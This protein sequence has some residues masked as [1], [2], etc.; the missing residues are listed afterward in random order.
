MEHTPS[1]AHA[2]SASPFQVDNTLE[3]KLWRSSKLADY[4]IDI[5]GLIVPIVDPYQLSELEKQQLL[6]HCRKT[7]FAIYRFLSPKI[8]VDK[9]V[10]QALTAQLGLHH[11]DHNLGADEDGVTA[12]QVSP[13]LG[14]QEYIPYTN[15]P[16]NWHTDGYYNSPEC[17]VHAFLIHCVHPALK[18]GE[19]QLYDHELAYIKLRDINPEYV[20][21]LMLPDVMT[22][23]ANQEGT[24]LIRAAQTGPVFSIAP[25][26]HLHM[27][28]T[29]RTRHIQWKSHPKVTAAI[30]TLMSILTQDMVFR[31]CLSANEGII[32]N[33]I[34]HNRSGFTDSLNPQQKRL[35][36]R[37]RFYDRIKMD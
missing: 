21:A 8:Q 12:L 18:G 14:T 36:Y 2:T 15:H 33:N 9:F 27:R 10:L 3:Y 35:L 4:P 16:L 32:C 30:Q 28:Y 13:A 25:Q 29:A 19:N 26:G 24:L 5:N 22:I 23:P 34:L 17:Q 7:N 1:T 31:Y 37:M 20:D 6:S 11:L